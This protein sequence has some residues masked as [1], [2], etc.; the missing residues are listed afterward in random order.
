MN[1]TVTFE[2]CKYED[3]E[4]IQYTVSG[5]NVDTGKEESLTFHNAAYVRI[6]TTCD[7]F[8]R[9]T[10]KAGGFYANMTVRHMNKLKEKH[11][12]D[13]HAI[14]LCCI[15]QETN[16]FIFLFVYLDEDD[17]IMDY[18]GDDNYFD[19]EFFRKRLDE[20]VI[21]EG[22]VYELES[23]DKFK[24]V[25]DKIV[26]HP[27][28]YFGIQVGGREIA[29]EDKLLYKGMDIFKEDTKQELEKLGAK[30]IVFTF[31]CGRLNFIHTK[32]KIRFADGEYMKVYQANS[33]I[34]DSEE[35]LKMERE[36]R[37]DDDYVMEDDMMKPFAF[38]VTIGVIRNI[39][40]K[41]ERME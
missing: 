20:T 12:R 34:K 1:N 31:D 11:G 7:A 29:Y 3:R 17:N 24:A 28:V 8:K 27:S 23:S 38:N 39:A 21:R 41:L 22:L 16:R 37:S 25:T 36:R 15:P 35:F 30:D 10:D 14:L 19:Y 13:V 4:Y 6:D 33:G 18:Q 40:E 26:P 32:G 9:L 2:L 5:K